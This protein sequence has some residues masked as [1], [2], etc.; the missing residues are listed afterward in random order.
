MPKEGKFT[1]AVGGYAANGFGLCDMHGNVWAVV[2]RLVRQGL[3]RPLAAR[4]SWRSR[5][6]HSPCAAGGG[7]NTFPLYARASFRNWN[8]PDTRCVNL[9]FRVLLEAER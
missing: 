9:G 2:C 6:G 5:V 8:M 1:V 3:L 4:R 7:W